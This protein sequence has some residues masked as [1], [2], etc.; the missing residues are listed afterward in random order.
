MKT[1]L[2]FR[3]R[4]PNLKLGSRMVLSELLAVCVSR[5]CIRSFHSGDRIVGPVAAV[6]EYAYVKY[7]GRVYKCHVDELLEHSRPS[8][9]SR[10][11]DT[12]ISHPGSRHTHPKI[13]LDRRKASQLH[14]IAQR[15]TIAH[16]NAWRFYG[17]QVYLFARSTGHIRP[18]D[19]RRTAEAATQVR[20]HGRRR[21]RRPQR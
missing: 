21:L 5:R 6:G 3:D 9:R 15:V 14:H 4:H 2:C 16:E 13:T 7:C 8:A 11:S 20:S 18:S 19:R 17:C 10:F 12:K 1:T